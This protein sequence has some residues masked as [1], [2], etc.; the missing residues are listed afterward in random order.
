MKRVSNNDKW[1]FVLTQRSGNRQQPSS[2]SLARDIDAGWRYF[3]SRRGKI[4]PPPI[5]N[6]YVH[7]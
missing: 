5:S 6:S 3:W 4:S 1:Q 7:K 2:S